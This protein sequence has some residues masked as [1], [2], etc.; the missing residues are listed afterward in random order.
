[1]PQLSMS[2]INNGGDI[3]Y[4]ISTYTGFAHIWKGKLFF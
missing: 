4:I 1:M 3:A 2:R